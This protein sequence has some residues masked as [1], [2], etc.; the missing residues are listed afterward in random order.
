LSVME[1]GNTLDRFA[2]FLAPVV[3]RFMTDILTSKERA[4]KHLAPIIEERLKLLEEHGNDWDGKPNDMLSWFLEEAPEGV[5]RTV[6]VLTDRVLTVNFAAIHTSSNSF[7]HAL[8]FLAEN[9]QYVQPLREEVETIVRK[10]GW[11]KSSLGKMRKIDS[12]MKESQRMAGLGSLGLVRVAVKDFTFS[13]GTF[14]PKGTYVAAP[15]RPLH[16]DDELYENANTFDPFRFSD[17]RD[18]E[19][20][21]TKHH[22]VSTSPE[23]LP[24]GHGRHACPGRFFAANELK[25]MLAHIVVTYDVKL[26]DNKPRP[27]GIRNGQGFFA[28]PSSKVM[29][30]KRAY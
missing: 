24:F 16:L 19:G 25:S 3:V 30:R 4:M 11:S 26:E 17:M 23:Y 15:S 10:E 7:V 22:F 27:E 6:R 28:D 1:A 29:F 9:P 12:F 21:G 2:D 5:E 8:F 18:E 20:G 14:I 13:D